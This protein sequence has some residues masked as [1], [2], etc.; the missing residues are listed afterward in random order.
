MYKRQ[1]HEG[2]VVTG[3]AQTLADNPGIT[4]IL[5]HSPAQ[6]R[7]AG[8]DPLAPVTLLHQAGLRHTYVVREDKAILEK[9]DV[10]SLRSRDV[11][12][13]RSVN[14]V[15]RAQSWPADSAVPVVS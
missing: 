15:M 4:V 1:G 10:E 5:E 3:M 11:K 13:G 12:T 2:A 14:L 7:L 8:L 9:I 6:A